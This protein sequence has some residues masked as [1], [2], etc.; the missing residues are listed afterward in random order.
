MPEVSTTTSWL[1]PPR[2]TELQFDEMWTFVGKKEAYCDRVDP[3]GDDKGDYWD[4]VAL[5]PEHRLVVE[6]VPVARTI[7]NTKTLVAS[8]RRRTGGRLTNLMTSDAYPAHDTAIRHAYGEAITPPRTGK[9]G[10]PRA[11]TRMVPEGLTYAVV[12]KSL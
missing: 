4:H 2:T 10:R 1:F 11:A 12:E 3:D 6:V 8:A 9:L 7:E 5:N